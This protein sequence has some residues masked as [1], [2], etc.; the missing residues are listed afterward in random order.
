MLMTEQGGRTYVA[1]SGLLSSDASLPTHKTLYAADKTAYTLLPDQNTL[2]VTLAAAPVNGVEVKKI[3]TF[4]RDSYVI[5]VRYDIINHSDKPVDATAYYRLLRDGKAP[6]GESSMAHTFTGP[7]VYTETGKFQKVS[8]EDLAKGKGDYVRQADNGWVAMVQHY[9]VSAWILKT[10][11]ASRYA[12]A[13]RPASSSSSRLRATSTPPAYWS[14]C[15][16]WPPAS[17]TASTCR[18]MP[19]RKTPAAWPPSHRVW[20]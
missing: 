7:A 14:S 15:R 6:E 9:F 4:K 16:S 10:N 12:A 8:F 18:C 19:V 2:T 3:F 20:C 17:S 11:D 1:Q 5:D 13:P